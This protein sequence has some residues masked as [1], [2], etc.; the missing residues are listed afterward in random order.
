MVKEKITF[1]ELSATLKPGKTSDEKILPRRFRSKAEAEREKQAAEASPSNSKWNFD[2]REIMS[3]NV[4]IK[5][6]D[7][8]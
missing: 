5:F 8:R 7:Q 3:I 4:D 6:P 1:Y 2:V